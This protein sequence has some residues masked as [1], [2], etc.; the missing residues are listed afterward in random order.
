LIDVRLTHGQLAAATGATRA[1]VTRVLGVMKK[2][3]QVWTIGAGPEQRFC[4]RSREAHAHV[5]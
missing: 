4:I 3:R 2:R 1:T 5:H